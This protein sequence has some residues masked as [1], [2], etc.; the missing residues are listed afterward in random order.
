M[1]L[2][3][4]R[5]G[6]LGGGGHWGARP[7]AALAGAAARALGELAILAGP[8]FRVRQYRSQVWTRWPT[9]RLTEIFGT[10]AVY[11][12]LVGAM[13]DGG[14]ILD[15]GMVYFDARLWARYPTVEVRIADVCLDSQD[16][17]LLAALSRALV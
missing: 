17:V 2:S 4:A 5:A 7:D 16:A 12:D 13:V 3:C 11:H 15:A 14:T 9:S 6:V 1:R 10:P 8:R